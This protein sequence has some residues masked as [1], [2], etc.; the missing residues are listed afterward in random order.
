[1]NP[2]FVGGI[3]ALGIAATVQY[4]LGVKKN[5]LIASRMSAA[6]EE[7]FAPKET[8]YVNIGG[9]IGHNFTYA[10]KEP[11]TE[12]K[13]AMT[14]SPRQSLLY[15]PLSRLIG[16]GDRFFA[17][18]YTKRAMLGEMHLVEA[19]HLRRAKIDGIGGMERREV[20]K[21]GKRFVMLWK[22]KDD[23][24]VLGA[25]LDALPDPSALRHF[26]CFP[27]NRTVFFYLAPRKGELGGALPVLERQARACVR[28]KEA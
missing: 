4:F 9:A 28:G 15:L 16:F 23:T 20:R 27:D 5:R 8:N 3:A 24:A 22:G 6:A 25:I 10:L 21:G 2:L 18:L 12:A 7:A 19:G 14:L 1:M 11:W 13:G 17:N 26:C